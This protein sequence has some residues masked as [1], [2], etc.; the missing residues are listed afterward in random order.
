MK[1]KNH[2]LLLVAI[3]AIMFMGVKPP[4]FAAEGIPEKGSDTLIICPE[5]RPQMCAMDFRPVCGELKNGSFKTFSNGCM[6]CADQ[7]VI[8]YRAGECKEGK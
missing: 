7:E 8:G 2:F 1:S 5:L 3:T 4:L 6:A